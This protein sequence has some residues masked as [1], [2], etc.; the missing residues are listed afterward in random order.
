VASQERFHVSTS[1]AAHRLELSDGLSATDDREML[2]A[3]F[4]SIEKVGEVAV[5]AALFETRL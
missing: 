4:D 2:A 1:T 3:V 5:S